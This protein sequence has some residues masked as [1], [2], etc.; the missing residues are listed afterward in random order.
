MNWRKL[1][2]VYCP[3]GARDW[4]RSY[5]LIPTVEPIGDD[6]LRI[7]Y[8]SVDDQRFGRVGVLEVDAA[9]PTRVLYDQPN[10]VLDLG[11]LGC[12]DDSGVN[13][14]ALVETALGT[15]LYYIGW[16]RCER[17]PYTLFAGAAL[18]QPDGSFCRVKR[19]PVLERTDREPFI[20]SAVTVVREADGYRCWYVS[21]HRWTEVNG[22]QYPEYVIRQTE[23]SDGFA[24]SEE[25]KLSIDFESPDEFGFGRPWV[26]KDPDRY[27]MW[28]SIRSRTEPYRLGY[29]E[30]PDGIVWT[31]MDHCMNLKRSAEG[32][33]SQ[34]IC[35][36]CVVDAAGKRY[37]FYNGNGHGSTGFGVAVLEQE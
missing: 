17:V 1:G 34:M 26:L 22:R 37:L 31:R 11:E 16:Q 21:A 15:T 35:Y 19:A 9:D 32:W 33:D 23:S 29:A 3:D 18:R 14:A 6:R 5:A 12:F 30:S 8:A 25:S 10:P 20:R 28:Y 36:P 7:Y 2:R 27:R 4:A 24:W 13:P